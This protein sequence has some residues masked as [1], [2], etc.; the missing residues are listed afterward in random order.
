MYIHTLAVNSLTSLDCSTTLCSHTDN[1]C[2]DSCTRSSLTC[3]YNI[4]YVVLIVN[5]YILSVTLEV[6]PIQLFD[7][8]TSSDTVCVCVCVCVCMNV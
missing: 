5:I 6:A 3:V 1:L 4:H 7:V 2:C 8:H